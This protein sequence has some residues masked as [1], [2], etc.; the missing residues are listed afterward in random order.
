LPSDDGKIV[1]VPELELLPR[2]R[3]PQFKGARFERRAPATRAVPGEITEADIVSAIELLIE[4]SEHAKT[5]PTAVAEQLDRAG[6][7]ALTG[8]CFRRRPI[9]SVFDFICRVAEEH[10]NYRIHGNV[11]F[12]WKPGA[13]PRSSKRRSRNRGGKR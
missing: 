11:R 10:Y 1:T 4:Q 6:F 7:T 2:I 5:S 12:I 13:A 8:N 9:E 3:G